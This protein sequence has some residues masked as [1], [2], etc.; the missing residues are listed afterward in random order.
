MFVGLAFVSLYANRT[1]IIANTLVS[2]VAF[3]L[4]YKKNVDLGEND[5]LLFPI[6]LLL[7]I[8]AVIIFIA[9]R[10]TEKAREAAFEAS[11]QAQL[12]KEKVEALLAEAN[13]TKEELMTFSDKLNHNLFNSKSIGAQI[14]DAYRGITEGVAGQ[15][16]N[17]SNINV[18]MQQIGATISELSHTIRDMAG[19]SKETGEVTSSYSEELK[20]IIQ[21]MDILAESIS[22]TY[23]VVHNLNEKNEQIAGILSTLNALSTQTNLLALNAS[24]EAARAGEHGKGFGVV[25][26]EVKK[27]AEDSKRS[28]E[29]I[30]KILGEIKSDTMMVNHKIQE[31]LQM[32]K[33]N[34]DIIENA[35]NTFAQLAQKTN[36]IEESAKLGDQKSVLLQES[37]TNIIHEMGSIVSISVQISASIEEILSSMENQDQHQQDVLDSFN[38]MKK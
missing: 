5:A 8:S 19:L 38:N 10:T 26:G 7:V 25:A 4:Y 32:V 31:E 15:T 17:I 29:I 36:T 16:Q 6:N 24:I 23:H 9:V 18:D 21:R 2:L 37:S 28:S 33:V 14:T 27:L 22:S 20:T 35:Q 12:S 11:A 13:A 1:A 34:K 3:D 30:G